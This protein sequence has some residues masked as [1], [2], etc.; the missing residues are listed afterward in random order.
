MTFDPIQLLAHGA[1]NRLRNAT[2]KQTCSHM[3]TLDR[4]AHV[5]TLMKC[6]RPAG[7]RQFEL[8]TLSHC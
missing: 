8:R 3:R 2:S 4:A 7:A 1:L 5:E 6:S